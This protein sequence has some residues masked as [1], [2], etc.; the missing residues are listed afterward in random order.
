VQNYLTWLQDRP[1]QSGNQLVNV[2]HTIEDL[3]YI[4][5]HAHDRTLAP[6]FFSDP[7][8][9]LIPVNVQ[10]GLFRQEGADQE[11]NSS[12]MLFKVLQELSCCCD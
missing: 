6:V 10:Q 11:M 4:I 9:L 12:F 5:E 2:G 3:G 7:S 1:R 8:P